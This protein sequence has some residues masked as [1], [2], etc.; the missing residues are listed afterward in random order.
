MLQGKGWAEETD[1]RRYD[2]VFRKGMLTGK[3]TLTVEG[4]CFEG[5]F[6]KGAP[7]GRFAAIFPDGTRDVREFRD[8]K[9]VEG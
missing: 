1:G 5:K 8:G 4:V 7:H 9:A 2:G 6:R 3:G